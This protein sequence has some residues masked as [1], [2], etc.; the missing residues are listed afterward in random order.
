[1]ALKKTKNLL[2]TI[3]GL[4]KAILAKKPQTGTKPQPKELL[5]LVLRQ[6]NKVLLDMYTMDIPM[7]I[8]EGYRSPER[9]AELYAQ[10]RTKR[11]AIV[12][13]AKPGE[14]LH[15]YG[16]ACDFVFADVGYNAS[17]VQWTLFGR[18][19]ERHGFEW[20]G[21]WKSFTDKPHLQMTL[22]YSLSDFQKGKVD[23]N[24]FK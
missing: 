8:T 10:G 19:A 18:T 1:M 24:K 7:K 16:C 12:T 14:S 21:R 6:A 4:Y 17:S 5:P 11:G 13:N 3:L 2:E 22:G 20:G 9:Q 23:Y 15:E